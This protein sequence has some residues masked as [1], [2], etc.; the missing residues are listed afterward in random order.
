MARGAAVEG[1]GGHG[2]KLLVANPDTSGFHSHF[3][4]REAADLVALRQSCLLG[5]AE[6]DRSTPHSLPSLGQVSMPYRSQC[7][8]RS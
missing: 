5:F 2:W 6:W 3:V 1:E 7:G 8:S 4:E